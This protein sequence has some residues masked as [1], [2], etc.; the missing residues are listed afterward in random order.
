MRRRRTRLGFA[1]FA[2]ERRERE[3]AETG[4]SALQELSS[5]S[6]RRDVASIGAARVRGNLHGVSC[7]AGVLTPACMVCGV[8]RG[9]R[10]G[11]GVP[12]LSSLSVQSY[13]K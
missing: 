11:P 12:G 1:L 9:F 6:A 8:V 4:R 2:V 10:T 7:S 13:L 3:P 5:A